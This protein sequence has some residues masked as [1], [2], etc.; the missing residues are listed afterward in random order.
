MAQTSRIVI[1]TFS[2]VRQL[3]EELVELLLSLIKLTTAG[4]VD[5]EE[6][7]DAIDDE[8]PVFVSHKELCDLVQKLHLMFRVDGSSI[9]DVVLGSELSAQ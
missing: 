2:N 4:V 9:G 1:L 3:R 7:H 5:P 8:K 6:C